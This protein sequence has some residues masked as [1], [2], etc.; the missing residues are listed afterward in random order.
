MCTGATCSAPIVRSASVN[1]SLKAMLDALSTEELASRR[2]AA[3]DAAMQEYAAALA[4]KERNLIAERTKAALQ[5]KRN[6]GAILGN[7]TN[8]AEAQRKGLRER[9]RRADQFAANILPVI[10][11]V[12]ATGAIS[13]TAIAD[14]LNMRGIAT[15]RGGEWYP[16]T[17]RKLMLRNPK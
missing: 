16:S 11:D 14:A 2:R 3:E 8:L 9:L 1:W 6:T 13:Y 17:V 10:R 15:A 12:Q 4:E 7:R 5:A